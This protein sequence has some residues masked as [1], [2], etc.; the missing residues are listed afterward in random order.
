MILDRTD[1]V[2]TGIRIAKSRPHDQIQVATSLVRRA[3][4]DKRQCTAH[5]IGGKD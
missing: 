3:S 2:W 5:R 4:P 1:S